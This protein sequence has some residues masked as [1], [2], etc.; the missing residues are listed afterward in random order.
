MSTMVTACRIFATL[1]LAWE[2]LEEEVAVAVEELFH[3]PLHLYLSSYLPHQDRY[4][5]RYQAPSQAPCLLLS[6]QLPLSLQ[7]AATEEEEVAAAQ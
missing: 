1:V 7:A 2:P 4:Q 6:L 3:K 5:D